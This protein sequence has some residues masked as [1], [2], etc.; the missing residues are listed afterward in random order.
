VKTGLSV[1]CLEAATM[2]GMQAARAL[3]GTSI[4][5]VG[6]LPATL[7]RAALPPYVERAGELVV[8]AP[9]AMQRVTMSCFVLAA[10]RA[11]LERLAE[12]HLNRVSRPSGTEYHAAAS[13]VTLAFADCRRG[14]ARD[15][16]DR[17]KGWLAERDVAFWVPLLAGRRQGGRF[18]AER[19]VWYL[20]YIFADNAAAVATGREIFGFP[21]Q[22]AT[23]TFAGDLDEPRFGVDTLVIERFG[24]ESAGTMARLIEVTPATRGALATGADFVQA[25]RGVLGLDGLGMLDVAGR[26]TGALLRRGSADARTDLVFLKQFRDAADP[27]RACYQAV[28]EAP[29]T[30]DAFR[31]GRP[32][33][34]HRVE[35]RAADSHPIVRELGLSGASITSQLA[36]S[37][38]FDFTMRE[39]R[40]V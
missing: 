6:D 39:G 36:G 27:S 25:V 33:A 19:L 14:Q 16:P 24:R 30:V 26:T 11:A 17:D 1:G 38:D 34:P 20:P 12:A 9:L 28:I 2:A 7:V 35:I 40:T 13:F 23:T 29:A 21:K 32:L 22:H 10:D 4:E 18:V 8:R 15:A 3:S 31:G 37:L 5:I